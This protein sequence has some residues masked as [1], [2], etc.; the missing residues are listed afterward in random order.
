[1]TKKYTKDEEL[2]LMLSE[3]FHDEVNRKG[4]V[5]LTP[6]E[7]RKW[8]DE[9]QEKKKKRRR[10]MI[11]A[12]VGACCLLLCFVIP[13]AIEPSDAGKTEETK[14]AEQNDTVVIQPE[15]AE[16]EAGLK[17]FT[18]TNWNEVEKLADKAE[19]LMIPDYIPERYEFEEAVLETSN[20]GYW[21]NYY[22]RCNEKEELQV[23][24]QNLEDED[25][26]MV[27]IESADYKLETQKG[28]LYIKESE[29]GTLD[30]NIK[31]QNSRIRIKGKIT[32][33]ECKMII[34]RLEF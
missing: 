26:S 13:M 7:L 2:E 19:G 21:V 3:F 18:E 5:K 8:D 33:Q 27:F 4:K 10:W 22:F 1:M 30:G 20:Q 9:L 28:L 11:P 32:S 24:Q 31:Y 15:H 23:M 29:D 16:G 12:V 25:L 14:V 17:S 34:E 6:D